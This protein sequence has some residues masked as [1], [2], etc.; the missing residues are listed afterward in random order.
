MFKRF[1]AIILTVVTVL[2]AIPPE[3]AL[4]EEEPGTTEIS[5]QYLRVVVNDENGGYVISTVDGDILKKTDDNVALTHRGKHFDTSFTSFKVGEEEYVFGEKYGLFGTGENVVT[6]FSTDGNLIRS[7]W[8]VDDFEVE[9]NIMLVDNDASEKLGTAQISYTVRNKSSVA[10]EV[11]SRILID[12]QLGD[13]DYGYY[14]LPNQRLGQGSTYFEFERTW[15]S[16]ANPTIVMP[17]DYFVR[18]NKYSTKIVGY[19]INSVYAEEKP[20]KMTFAHWANIAA[21]V[22]DYE[23]DRTLNFTNAIN[24]KRTADSASALYYDLGSI[25]AGGE[26]KFSTYYGVTANLK[27]KDNQIII[28]TTAPSKLEFKDDTRTAYKGSQEDV[29][30]DIV[31]INVHL[32][33]PELSKKDYDSITVVAYAIGFGT[34]RRRD[35]GEWVEYSNEDPIYTKISDFK[36]GTN[37]VTYFDFKFTPKERAQLGSFVIKIFN[38]DPKINESGY[39]AEEFCLGSTENHIIIP[40]Q[41]SSLPPITL[42]GL[43]PEIIYNQDIRYLTVCGK[44]VNFFKSELLQKVSLRSEDGTDYEIPRE[45]FIFEPEANAE[46]VSIM[47]DEYMKP[48]RYQLHFYWRTDTELGALEGIPSDFTSDAM[49]VQVSSDPR[50]SNFTYGIVTVQRDEN[51]KYK[52]VPYKDEAALESAHISEDDLLLTFRGDLLQERENKNLYRLSGKSKNVT[53]NNILNY[54]GDALTLEQKTDGTVEVRM[55]GKLTTIGA[56]TTVRNGTAVFRLKAGV[57]YLVPIYN[58]R[59]EV[60]EDGEITNNKQ[61]FIEVKW[62]NAF[63]TLATVGGFLIDFKYGILGKIK[64]RDSDELSDIISFGGSLDIGFMTPGGAAAARKNTAEGAKW[65][66]EPDQEIIYTDDDDDGMTFGLDFDE[67]EGCF[68]TQTTKKETEP[69]NEENEKKAKRVSGGV[70][71]Y[72]ILYGGK[73]PGFVGIN[74]EAY[75]SLPQIVKFLPQ[76]IDA[77]IAVNTIGGYRVGVDAE[78]KMAS[79]EVNLSLVI[80]SSKSGAPIPDKL[81]LTI[82]GFEPGTN[83][84]GFGVL[85]I[86]GGGGGIDNLYD[87]IYNTGAVPPLSIILNVQFD[88]TKIMTGSAELELSLRSLRVTLDDVSL[89]KFKDAKFL[90]GGYIA[91]GWYPNA[92]FAF[93]AGVTYAQIMSGRLTISAGAGKSLDAYI[94]FVLN[95]SISLPKW[96]PFVGDMPLAEAEL[97]GGSEKVWGSLTLLKKIK[98]GFVYYWGGDIE[99]T[100]GDPEGME[101][102]ATS[103]SGGPLSTSQALYKEMISPFAIGTSSSGETEYASMGGNLSYAAG[104]KFVSDF[105]TLAENA[106][107]PPARRGLRGVPKTEIFTNNERT[108]HLVKFGPACDYI[109]VVGRTDGTELSAQDIKGCMSASKNGAPYAL[110]YYES[111]GKD[112]SDEAKAAALAEANVNVSGKAAYIVI[113]E[114]DANGSLL[115]E[116]SDGNAYDVSAVRVNPLPELST[117]K[118]KMEGNNLKVEWTGT[119]LSDNAKI[120]VSASDG[121]EENTIILNEQD[122]KASAGSAEIALSEKMASGKYKITVTLSEE[123]LVHHSIDAGEVEITNSNA[124]QAADRVTIANCGDNMLKVSVDTNQTDFSGYMVEIYEEDPNTGN[125]MLVDAGKYFGKDEEILVGGRFNLPVMKTDEDGKPIL[126]NEGNGIPQTDESGNPVTKLV[127]YNPGSTYFAKIRLCNIKKDTEG[128]EIFHCSAYKTSEGVVLKEATPP[129]P[130][131]EYDK[132]TKEIKLKSPG[133]PVSGEMYINAATGKGDWYSYP[134]RST[135][136]VQPVNLPDGEHTIEFHAEDAEGDHAVVTQIINIDT[137]APVMLFDSP[138]D[139]FEGDSIAVRATADPDAE[140]T[141]KINGTVVAPQEE[142]IFAGGLMKCTLNIPDE[143][144]NAGKVNLQVIAKDKEGNETSVRMTLVNKKITKITSISIEATNKQLTAGKLSL[145]EGESDKLRVFGMAGSEKID[146]SDL[147]ATSLEI[148]SGNSVKMDGVNVSASSSGQSLV[149]ATF[150]LGGNDALYDGIVVEVGAG[151]IYDALQELIA[152]AKQIPSAGY[153]QQAWNEL[154]EAIRGAEQIVAA[155]DAA[156]QT[157]IDNAST[158]LSNAMAKVLNSAPHY[159]VVFNSN[160]GSMVASQKIEWGLKA[161]KPE[162]PVKE[163]YIFAGWFVDREFSTPYSFDD[164]VR[165]TIT[166]YAKWVDPDSVVMFR[167]VSPSDYFY[168]AVQWAVIMDITAG[169]SGTTFSPNDDCT[170]AHIATFLWKAAGKP[171]PKSTENPFIDVDKSDYFYK[172]VL[173]AVEN[174]ITAGTGGGKF[175]PHAVCTRAQALTLIWKAADKPE[176]KAGAASF[177][178]VKSDAYYADAVNWAYDSEITAGTGGGKFSPDRNCTRAQIVTFLYRAFGK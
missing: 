146:I 108:S 24:E 142:D 62:D 89:K 137:T 3:I 59:G 6:E 116:F 136:I 132:D 67:K 50:Y 48:G 64:D 159:F 41:D 155:G 69:A 140:Y 79:V 97:G 98:V 151:L 66:K 47:L 58:D 105:D 95:V 34:Q 21:T 39:Y 103:S 117:A 84:D 162:N 80:K 15:D 172:A 139:Y 68:V 128:N 23:P 25:P 77:N 28:N 101:N 113:P 88:I 12:T 46:H 8:K 147:P 153:E 33:N 169:T 150:A 40:G 145:G 60:I 85:W 157:D 94:E 42:T 26:K 123:N 72:D 44:G 156:T 93:S 83:V 129:N 32:T 143:Y 166:L 111:P 63:D 74:M 29:G 49:Y 92:T 119:G 99:F 131:I 9:Q 109:L 78:V 168:D 178:D 16:K 55:D 45:N 120:I 73:K 141:F 152:E 31:R 57:D 13:N 171:E 160:G 134:D 130:T 75:F 102:F 35:D 114:G 30:D 138:R 70:S 118:A 126:D 135:E 61:D 43:A 82:G 100:H 2:V 10:K 112:A 90:D 37:K 175:S 122:I 91:I 19:G 7:T 14:E 71:I 27:N 51:L 52:I 173:W 104:S 115:L 110:V 76:K 177:S 5:N 133:V 167:D 121:K 170:R 87:T 96:I 1:L 18:D 149:C 56:N 127:G 86:T 20:Y 158:A 161:L 148:M 11:K 124:P 154:Q 176:A 81:Y 54:K 107:N 165:R 17:A 163:G 38:T 65:T 125:A 53:I 164:P 36:S 4:A 144:K 174:G 106:S 22:F